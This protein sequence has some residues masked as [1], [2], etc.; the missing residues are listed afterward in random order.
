MLSSSVTPGVSERGGGAPWDNC[1]KAEAI[2]PHRSSVLNN[3]EVFVYVVARLRSK[4]QTFSL[5]C[6]SGVN[7]LIR[8][9]GHPKK[10]GGDT[11]HDLSL[12]RAREAGSSRGERMPCCNNPSVVPPC[13]CF[14]RK[15][16]SRYEHVTRVTKSRLCMPLTS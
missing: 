7:L 10:I 5:S 15:V 3:A 9:R 13:L 6:L 8:I 4:Q 12:S 14:H 11:Y 16:S 1:N 2:F